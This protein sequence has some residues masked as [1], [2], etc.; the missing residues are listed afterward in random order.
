MS[1]NYPASPRLDDDRYRRV[2]VLLLLSVHPATLAEAEI[3]R[4]IAEDSSFA[5]QDAVAQALR[6]LSA[7]GVIHRRDRSVAL[8]RTAVVTAG[9]LEAW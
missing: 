3:E 2:V 1:A 7:A 5:A 9:L 6:D 4:E 8:T